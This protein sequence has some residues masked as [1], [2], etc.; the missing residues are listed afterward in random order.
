[1]YKEIEIIKENLSS[2][3]NKLIDRDEDLYDALEEMH[4]YKDILFNFLKTKIGQKIYWAHENWRKHET[5]T[6][7]DV[8]I[9]IQKSDFFGHEYVGKECIRIYIKSGGYFIADDIG[10]TLFFDEAEA[11]SHT[12]KE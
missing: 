2:I 4:R 3:E 1:M 10:K 7:T 11:K 5:H 12:S 9:D 8:G 6:V